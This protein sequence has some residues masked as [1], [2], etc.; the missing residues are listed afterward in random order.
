M[1]ACLFTIAIIAATSVACG[2]SDKVDPSVEKLGRATGPVDPAGPMPAG[3]ALP[4][5]HPAIPGDAN[6]PHG[7]MG[8]MAGPQGPATIHVGTVVE[9]IDVPNYTYI[10]FKDVTGEERW[11]AIPSS[12]LA[13]GQEVRIAESMTMRDFRSP[14]LNRVFPVII[15]GTLKKDEAGSAPDAG[16]KAPAAKPAAKPAPGPG[17][18]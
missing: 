15:F 12:K 9:T 8:Q 16:V 10:H 18:K 5:G 6:S 13:A 17:K 3:T 14:S 11:A 7:Q 4:P 2:T 1:K